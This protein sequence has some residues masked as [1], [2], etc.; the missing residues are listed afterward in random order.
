MLPMKTVALSVFLS[1]GVASFAF[2]DVQLSF[3]DG[4]VS[5]VAK[6]ATVG[7][8]L[9]EWAKVGQTKMVNV[10]RIPRERLTIELANV[11]EGRALEVV[12]RTMSGYIAASRTVDMPNASQFDR[13][14]VLPTSSVVPASAPPLAA[15]GGGQPSESQTPAYPSQPVPAYSPQPAAASPQPN[16]MPPPVANDT[17]SDSIEEPPPFDVGA[18]IP[19]TESRVPV[20]NTPRQ[21][22]ET[23]DPAKFRLDVQAQGGGTAVAPK[24]AGLPGG[25]VAVPG[26]IAPPKGPR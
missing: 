15:K 5:I 23:V 25:G 21:A 19:G 10:E 6:D 13:I 4:H 26:M 11:S 3:H 7:Q 17:A 16:F 2:A 1:L 22:L 12:L 8:I 18:V 24:P 14:I 9:A 20:R